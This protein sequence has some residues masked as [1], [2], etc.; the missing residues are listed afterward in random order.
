MIKETKEIPKR[1]PTKFHRHPWPIC[2]FL[3]GNQFLSAIQWLICFQEYATENAT[4]TFSQLF[5]VIL[6]AKLDV[7]GKIF[8]AAPSAALFIESFKT[9]LEGDETDWNMLTEPH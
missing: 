4:S 2:W 7:S 9:N 3:A 1:T 6:N 8:K 5:Q